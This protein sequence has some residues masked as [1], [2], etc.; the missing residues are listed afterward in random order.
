[1]HK[2]DGIWDNVLFTNESFVELTRR[3]WN[4]SVEWVLLPTTVYT[5]L[6]VG[7]WPNTIVAVVTKTRKT[8]TLFTS[9]MLK[10][11]CLCLW[12][13][14][15]AVTQIKTSYIEIV[16]YWMYWVDWV[17]KILET[18]FTLAILRVEL[19]NLKF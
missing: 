18:T 9:A 1:M 6:F 16:L 11:G 17:I 7:A 10:V 13:L 5:K 19:I 8:N 12:I 4:K 14:L 3:Y 2:P 15:Q